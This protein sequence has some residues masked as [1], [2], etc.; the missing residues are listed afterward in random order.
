MT[1]HV[2]CLAPSQSFRK[3]SVNRSNYYYHQWSQGF[4]KY[5]KGS[6]LKGSKVTLH[7]TLK[8]QVPLL[9]ESIWVP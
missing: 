7:E 5:R 9:L 4:G 2:K 1:S 3:G 6:K 8:R